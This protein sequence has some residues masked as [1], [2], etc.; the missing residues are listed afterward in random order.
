[1]LPDAEILHARDDAPMKAPDHTHI[2][3]ASSPAPRERD[4]FAPFNSSDGARKVVDVFQGKKVTISEDLA[5][6]ARLLSSIEEVIRNGGGQVTD[7]V[8]ETDIY[9][10][11]YRDGENYRSASRLGK[12]VG[13]L[14]WLYHL[15]T[16]NTWISPLR[17]LLHY[18]VAK[19]GIPGFKDFKISLSNYA[20]EARVYLENLIVASGAECTKTLKQENTHLITAHGNS[21]KC[22]AAREWN[23]HVVNH[24]WLED[25]Y[26]KWKAQSVSTPRYTHF[27]KRTNLGEIVG[28]TRI[29]RS[30]VEANF[31]PLAGNQTGS[32]K[33]AVMRRKD[34]NVPVNN[35]KATTDDTDVQ[36]KPAKQVLSSE[37]ATPKTAAKNNTKVD[38]NKKPK[39]AGLQTPHAA[40]F[41]GEGKENETPST[42]GSRKSK[43]L[44][45][46][47][48]HNYAPD[49][50]LY[51][52]ERK[53][54]GGVIFGGRRKSDEDRVAVRK[55]SAETDDEPGQTED[56]VKPK[57]SKKPRQ[58]SM[59]LLT[60]LYSR[61]VGD[62]K[63]E[64][65]DKVGFR[66][67]RVLYTLFG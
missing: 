46:T 24:L 23:L 35:Q 8:Q 36:S 17:R 38:S 43:D 52:K 48:L 20:G 51:E 3:G 14:S 37:T 50:A 39:D 5:I 67:F 9:V 47:R 27:P 56:G 40:K 11:R 57:K 45:T 60:T 31:F 33:T 16:R 41:V 49:L 26:A 54:V 34:N 62:S 25:S 59:Y 15:I 55:R 22:N 28:Q 61:W 12:D 10:C 42:T 64:A 1:M 18:P 66:S 44:A 53:R 30:A 21:E 6:G 2:K 19:D 13:N 58:I 32:N 63:Q 65:A 7:D 29:D 4:L